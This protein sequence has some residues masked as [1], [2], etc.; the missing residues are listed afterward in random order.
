[1][2]ALWMS[3]TPPQRLP[4]LS[5]YEWKAEYERE[6]DSRQKPMPQPPPLLPPFLLLR[7][8]VYEEL[9][10][11]ELKMELPMLNH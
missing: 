3:Q 7:L 10:E 8:L 4:L 9:K 6:E 1:V 11:L 5:S 2:I